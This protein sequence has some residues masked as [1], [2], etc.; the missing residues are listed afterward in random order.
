MPPIICIALLSVFSLLI[1]LVLSFYF[2]VFGVVF[3]VVYLQNKTKLKFTQRATLTYILCNYLQIMAIIILGLYMVNIKALLLIAISIFIITPAF[4]EGV[5]LLVN[6]VFIRKNKKFIEYAT[7]KLKK[8]NPVKIA[9]T[10]SYGKT[11]CKNILAHLLQND[12]KVCPTEKNYN[13][14]MG[15]AITIDKMKNDTQI[16]IAEMGARKEGD[17]RE[18]CDMIEP[19][20]G[21]ITGITNQHLKTFGT[22]ENIYEEKSVLAKYL[23]DKSLC[24]FNG[25]DKYALKMYKQHKGRKII[26]RQNNFADIY[27][28]DIEIGANGSKFTINCK[29][30]RLVCQTK[31]LGRHNIQNILLCSAIALELGVNT[32]TLIDLIGTIPQVEHRLQLIKSNGIN[33]LDDSYNANILGIKYSLECLSYFDT[34]KVVFSQGIIELGNEQESANTLIGRLIAEVADTVILC[35]PNAR[36]IKKGLDETGYGKKIH[37]FSTLK[38]AKD[39][40]NDILKKG[41]TLLIQNDIPDVF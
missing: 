3:F 28:N 4:M 8:C 10:G 30:E 41:D 5:L 39:N 13:T 1:H 31:L 24:V 40:F 21:I 11:S 18:L 16:F 36:D 26:V 20:Y 37:I 7:A 9:I 25:S 32:R 2:A 14:P 22:I 12:F 27:A 17:I 23:E 38:E 33:I 19:D 29:D 34:R 35:G 15:L 6:P